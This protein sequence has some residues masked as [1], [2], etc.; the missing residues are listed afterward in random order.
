MET[1]IQTLAAAGSQQDYTL[2]LAALE[3]ALDPTI[4]I[5]SA[6][7]IKARKHWQEMLEPFE[8]QVQN[9][10]TFCRRAPVAL[11]A[12]DVGLGKTISAGLILSELRVRGA[13][14]RCLVLAPKLLGPQW[15]EELDAKFGISAEDAVGQDLMRAARGNT[16]VVVTTYHSARARMEQL[17]DADFDMLI[18]DEAHHLRNLHG[19]AN[20]PK[21]AVAVRD[22][23]AARSFK[24]VLMLT[25][26]PIQ[27]RLWDLYSLVDMLTVA[28]GHDNPLGGKDAFVRRY[29]ADTRTEAR[30]LHPGRQEEFRR[31]LSQYMVRTRR[32]DCGLLFPDRQVQLVHASPS[33]AERSLFGLVASVIDGMNAL[34]QTSVAQALMS[35][36]QALLA[37]LRNMAGKGRSSV[38]HQAVRDVAQVV[39]GLHRTGKEERLLELLRE[40]KQNRQDDW[41]VVIFTGRKETQDRL[42]EVV[43]AEFGEGLCGFIRGGQASANQR[44]I[45]DYSMSPPARNVVI[46]TDAGAEG[47]NLQKGNV[48]VNYDL[49]WNPMLVEQRIGR[50]QR[51]GS[52]HANVSVLNLV[53]RGSVEEHV[54]GRLQEKLTTISATIGDIEGVLE[55]MGPNGGDEGSFESVIRD[56]VV[57]SLKG[58]DV[59]DAVQR[60]I[61]SIERAKKIYEDER[62]EVEQQLGRMDAM[63]RE[64]PPMPQLSGVEPRL[65]E[66]AFTLAALQAAGGNV[67]QVDDATYRLVRP[68]FAP[69]LVCFDADVA[70]RAGRERGIAGGRR[71]GLYRSGQAPFERL[72]ADWAGQA[73]V[74]V[75]D[76]RGL[77]RETAWAAVTSWLRSSESDLEVRDVSVGEQVD[78]F[79]GALVFRS[80]ASVAHDK[81]EKLVEIPVSPPGHDEPPSDAVATA[82]LLDSTFDAQDQRESVE[83][84]VK[85]GLIRDPDFEA[86]TGFYMRRREEEL[87]RAKG[88]RVLEQRATEDFTPTLSARLVGADGTAYSIVRVR[89]TLGVDGASAPVDVMMTSWGKVVEA[90]ELATCVVTGRRVPVPMMERCAVTSFMACRHLL[91]RSAASGKYAIPA[92]TGTCEATGVALL[93]SELGKSVVSGQEVDA[94]LLV[95]SQAGGGLALD[96]E[97]VECEVTGKRCLPEE[98]VVSGVSGR[99]FVASESRTGGDAGVTGHES[100]FAQC[101]ESERWFP[102]AELGRSDVTGHAVATSLLA[103]SEKP[104]HRMGAHSEI[105]SC[106]V[107]GKQLLVDEVDTSVVTGDVVDVD[108][109]EGSALS[110]RL[111]EPDRLVACEVSGDRVL[112]DEIMICHATSKAVRKDLLARSDV[113]GSSVLAS[114]LIQSAGSQRRGLR[115]EMV[116]CV[117]DGKLRV[118]ADTGRCNVTGL[119]IGAEHLAEGRTLNALIELVNDESAG[120]PFSKA[121]LGAR[122]VDGVDAILKLKDPVALA[123]PDAKG[124]LVVGRRSGFL[125]FGRHLR[126]CYIRE[127]K[128]LAEGRVPD[129]ISS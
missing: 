64:G 19:T 49:P 47:V 30:R 51:L 24:Y 62:R 58:R 78:A 17:A 77:S 87:R 83:E 8:H 15:R 110:G 80:A 55:S 53:L 43:S 7:D 101:S 128:I 90:P 126:F 99:R 38:D 71:V 79:R 105:R 123:S 106:A 11:I 23:L 60:Q 118:P 28:K 67:E 81:Y 34:V 20:P 9:L 3:W 50:V 14:D 127:N 92:E 29:I 89:G 129:A 63:H 37:Q 120:Y 1:D 91:V 117:W 36:P 25:A 61:A 107:S 94:R 69:E 95:A 41:R 102:H 122:D 48:V 46:S 68:G 97:L 72:V 54:V 32:E 96:S 65:A 124:V 86:F 115:D 121:D 84:I 45:R 40:L 33:A 2:H 39:A 10:I 85:E 4:L 88:K 112:P 21:M 70:R 52:E 13:V 104:P 6:E 111:A 76:L 42:G 113:S 82:P 18:L 75:R 74:H 125:G 98:L 57:R 119:I 31:H 16:D 108:L 26:T 44:A 109:L 100:E 59:E 66:P 103:R 12:D 73:H 35:S 116:T 22:A 56:L 114:E 93:K 5:H 27:N